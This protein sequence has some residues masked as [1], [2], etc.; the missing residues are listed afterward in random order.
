[1]DLAISHIAEFLLGLATRPY[2]EEFRL[3]A[4]RDRTLLVLL[5]STR[6]K[7]EWVVALEEEE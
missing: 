1:M 2:R 4:V 7:N 3:Q 6:M 5:V